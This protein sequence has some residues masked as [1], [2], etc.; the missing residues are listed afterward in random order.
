MKIYNTI[1]Y[2]KS[3]IF[4][5]FLNRDND[6]GNKIG[7][8]KPLGTQY[9]FLCYIITHKVNFM[10]FVVDGVAVLE[11]IDSNNKGYTEILCQTFMYPFLSIGG[12]GC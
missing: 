10:I 1:Y 9:S 2:L 8:T 12:R 6:E 7:N 5:A 11:S 3:L 4:L